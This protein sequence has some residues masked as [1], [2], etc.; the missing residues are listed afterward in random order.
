LEVT[1]LL[2]PSCGQTALLGSC[3]SYARVLSAK[4][5]DAR[6]AVGCCLPKVCLD[7]RSLAVNVADSRALSR[8]TLGQ[9]EQN[10]STPESLRKLCNS[11]RCHAL[12]HGQ[13]SVFQ[14]VERLRLNLVL[15]QRAKP[16]NLGQTRCGGGDGLRE[17]LV[18]DEYS[19]AGYERMSISQPPGR[20]IDF[21]TWR[22]GGGENIVNSVAE[23]GGE[24]CR[25]AYDLEKPSTL[26]VSW[27]PPQTSS[28]GGG[29]CARP[30]CRHAGDL[31]QSW[32]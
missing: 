21:I 17:R 23:P 24:L 1:L 25:P 2:L 5:R 10:D 12:S 18:L 6:A 11:T 28:F 4:I 8:L 3:L 16:R 31:K 29:G 20:K 7:R 13:D 27:R 32:H 22:I 26:L 30:A 14:V 15:T 19:S 9:M